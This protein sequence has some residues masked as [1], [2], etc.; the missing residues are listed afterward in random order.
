MP[1]LIHDPFGSIEQDLTGLPLTEFISAG[2]LLSNKLKL[3]G[4][5]W[6]RDQIVWLGDGI[7]ETLNSK[8]SSQY[9]ITAFLESRGLTVRSDHFLPMQGGHVVKTPRYTLCASS[10]GI[11][12]FGKGQEMA[13]GLRQSWPLESLSRFLTGESRRALLAFPQLTPVPSLDPLPWSYHA[14]LMLFPLGGNLLLLADPSAGTCASQVSSPMREAQLWLSDY[15]QVLG[16]ELLP[17]PLYYR[18][19]DG[20]FHSPLNGLI[21]EGT[22]YFTLLTGM[23]DFNEDVLAYAQERLPVPSKPV[24]LPQDLL[25]SGGGLR[26]LSLDW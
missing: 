26:C 9:L 14:D 13:R 23:D 19:S 7:H 17:F 24:Y 12:P 15:L 5:T 8:G 4:E 21:I 2:S 6:V 25:G 20:K 10:A 22:Y 1:H 11:D 3:L 16:Y 18:A